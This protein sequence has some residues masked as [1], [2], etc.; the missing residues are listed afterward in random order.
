MAPNYSETLRAVRNVC[1]LSVRQ[2]AAELDMPF[3]SYSNFES[4]YR[5]RPFPKEFVERVVEVLRPLKVK[6][7][8]VD[9]IKT[10]RLDEGR[11]RSRST[12]EHRRRA[13]KERVPLAEIKLQLTMSA[14]VPAM[15]VEERRR[16]FYY[17]DQRVIDCLRDSV[18]QVTS[19][20]ELNDPGAGTGHFLL[21]A[22]SA[23]V[24]G[25]RRARNSDDLAK[26]LVGALGLDAADAK[27]LADFLSHLKFPN[28]PLTTQVRVSAR[29]LS[30]KKSV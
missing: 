24:T 29:H 22:M 25:S 4:R 14:I 27:K 3:T 23:L 8:F 7:A 17:T 16:Q 10:G 15:G 30:P 1:G 2:F 20:A 18:S 6:R 9:A 12:R 28:N 26:A 13:G 19:H 11:T 21:L 5:H